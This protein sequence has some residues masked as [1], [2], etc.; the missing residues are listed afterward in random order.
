M[1]LK[2]IGAG[3]VVFG[4]VMIIFFPFIEEYQPEALSYAGVILGI[5]FLGIGLF[6]LKT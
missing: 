6:L 3:L 2:V 4:L 1:W 5:I